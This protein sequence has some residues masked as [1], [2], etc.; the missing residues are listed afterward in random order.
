VMS[1]DDFKKWVD[2][3]MERIS[4]NIALLGGEPVT[5]PDFGKFVEYALAK[6]KAVSIFTNLMAPKKNAKDLLR[7]ASANRGISIIWNNSEFAGIPDIHQTNS[8]ALATELNKVCSMSY[9]VTYTPGLDLSYLLPMAEKTGIRRIRFALNVSEMHQCIEPKNLDILLRH[10]TLLI[11]NGFTIISDNCGFIPNSIPALYRLRFH[12]L[13]DEV[14][15]CSGNA[16]DVLPDGRI[17]PCMPYL[18]DIKELYVTDIQSGQHLQ[19]M[20]AKH[21]GPQS[22][23]RV[24]QGMCPATYERPV[25]NKVIPILQMPEVAEG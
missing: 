4:K 8:L 7:I 13:L 6:N 17:I 21:Y 11:D 25:K 9:S 1:L 10:L 23:R 19:E 3:D 5:H 24:T 18:D 12:K 16:R 2:I 15:R 22:S 14:Q 20:F